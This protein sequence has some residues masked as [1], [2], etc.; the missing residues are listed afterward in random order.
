MRPE[1]R[2]ALGKRFHTLR[3]ALSRFDPAGRHY[4]LEKYVADNG[5]VALV[6]PDVKAKFKGRARLR[7]CF[8]WRLGKLCLSAHLLARRTM[9]CLLSATFLLRQL[10]AWKTCKH[11]HTTLLASL[12]AH[13]SLLHCGYPSPGGVALLFRTANKS[14]LAELTQMHVSIQ[15]HFRCGMDLASLQWRNNDS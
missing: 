2:W 11:S 8:V 1:R 7:S 5:D 13:P 15:L 6:V 10:V 12:Q 14:L 3:E 9:L 4:G